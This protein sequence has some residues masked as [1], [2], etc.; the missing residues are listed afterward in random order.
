MI[1]HHPLLRR[2]FSNVFTA[3]RTF[4][5]PSLSHVTTVVTPES[6]V[7]SV[8]SVSP[9]TAVTAVTKVSTVSPALIDSYDRRHTYLRISLTERCNFRCTYCMPLEGVQLTE[10]S[11][12]MTVDEQKRSISIFSALGMTKLRFTG[13]E[14]L[15]LLILL[16]KYLHTIVVSIVVPMLFVGY[17]DHN[18]CCS[19][20]F[21]KKLQTG[22]DR[23]HWT[24]TLD[25][26][27]YNLRCIPL[28]SADLRP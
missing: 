13:G 11:K 25:Y 26:P 2:R 27:H 22:M 4:S 19:Y 28:I 12:L 18:H 1:R 6:A 23:T 16:T 20:H 3:D 24:L 21:L 14:L 8:P 15:L 7:P 5:S 9:V 10:Q 17:S